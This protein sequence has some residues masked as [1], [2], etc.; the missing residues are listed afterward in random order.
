MSNRKSSG[1]ITSISYGSEA[2][3]GKSFMFSVTTACACPRTAAASTCLSLGSFAMAG[4][5]ASYPDTR[6]SGNVP[7]MASTIPLAFKAP[8]R[9]PT[10]LVSPSRMSLDQSGS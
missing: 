5:S 4:M 2:S 3:A 7:A 8:I 10:F 6:L 9:S 1:R